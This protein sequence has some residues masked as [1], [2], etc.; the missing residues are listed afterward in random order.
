MNAVEL[1]GYVAYAPKLRHTGDGRHFV[2]FQLSVKDRAKKNGAFVDVY[3]LFPVSMWGSMAVMAAD[4]YVKGCWI[5]V[6]GKLKPRKYIDQYKR[7]RLSVEVY[8][9][10]CGIVC[11]PKNYKPKKKENEELIDTDFPAVFN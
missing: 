9:K 3:N 5:W 4:T 1:V 6:K 2:T 10:E 8:V 11:F 7:E